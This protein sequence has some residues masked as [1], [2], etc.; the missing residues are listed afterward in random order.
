[1]LNEAHLGATLTPVLLNRF[2]QGSETHTHT[3]PITHSGRGPSRHCG[4]CDELELTI[5][6]SSA[7]QL[8]PHPSR[9]DNRDRDGRSHD[10]SS[11]GGGISSSGW[12][13]NRG[14]DSHAWPMPATSGRVCMYVCVYVCVRVCVACG[15]PHFALCALL[16]TWDSCPARFAVC[17]QILSVA[18]SINHNQTKH[19]FAETFCAARPVSYPLQ[20]AGERRDRRHDSGRS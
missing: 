1:M 12:L 16:P 8:R 9:R 15:Q 20:G 19:D 2:S 7:I 4:P 11:R 14:N 18:P 6:Q 10:N 3:H 13:S 5:A 17:S